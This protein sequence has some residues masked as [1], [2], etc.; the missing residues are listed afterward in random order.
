MKESYGSG[1]IASLPSSCLDVGKRIS[2]IVRPV[3]VVTDVED[4]ISFFQLKKRNS[5]NE[6]INFE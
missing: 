1:D 2:S 4:I 5:N 6:T 3:M